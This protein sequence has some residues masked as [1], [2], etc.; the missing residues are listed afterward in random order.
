MCSASVCVA[1][2]VYM[3]DAPPPY[4]GIDPSL[5]AAYPPAPPQV[6]GHYPA[7][8]AAAA[9]ATAPYPEEPQTPAAGMYTPAAGTSLMTDFYSTTH[10]VQVHSVI[11]QFCP[12]VVNDCCVL[13]HMLGTCWPHTWNSLPSDIRSYHTSHTFKKHLKTHLFR[14]S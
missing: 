10:C 2:S 5:P 8:A 11:Q 6:N 3:Y 14:Q 1:N 4:P 9:A 7:N 13:H 12:S